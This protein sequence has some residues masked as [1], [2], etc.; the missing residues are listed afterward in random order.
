MAQHH[1]YSITELEDMMPYERDVYVDMLL[2][3][4]AKQKQEMEKGR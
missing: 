1:N 2:A 4:L 3:F